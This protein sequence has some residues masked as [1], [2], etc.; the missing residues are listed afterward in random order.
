MK[1]LLVIVL[2]ST[3]AI[4]GCSFLG[5]HHHAW[6]DAKQENPLELPPGLDQ[7]ATD[8]A[9]RIPPPSNGDTGTD[10]SGTSTNQ[11]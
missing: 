11:Q 4:S 5:A 2:L 3:L 9:M 7:P 6:E 10:Q 1:K 8:N